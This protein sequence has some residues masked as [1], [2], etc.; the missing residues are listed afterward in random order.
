MDKNIALKASAIKS[1]VTDNGFRRLEGMLEKTFPLNKLDQGLVL[2]VVDGTEFKVKDA[3]NLIHGVGLIGNNLASCIVGNLVCHVMV[4]RK[5][6]A[7]VLEIHL[8]RKWLEEI[9]TSIEDI[10]KR[11]H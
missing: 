11:Q 5:V 7:R 3:V 1:L 4:S 10:L 2:K 9:A 6:Y 8:H